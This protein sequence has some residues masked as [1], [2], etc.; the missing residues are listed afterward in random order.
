V[1]MPGRIEIP[2][3]MAEAPRIF[4][5]WLG[6]EESTLPADVKKHINEWRIEHEA[7]L[8]H[9]LHDRYGHYVMVMAHAMSTQFAAQ[10]WREMNASCESA[11]QYMFDRLEQE[12]HD[13][14]NGQG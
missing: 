13:D 8:A 12:M 11:N 10:F 3:A 4:L 1:T 14:R 6:S 7:K 2:F 5:A 9:Y